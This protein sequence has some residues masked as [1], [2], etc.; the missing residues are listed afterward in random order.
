MRYNVAQ[1]LKEGVGSVRVYAV[2]EIVPL[3]GEEW[4][5]CQVR[6]QVYLLRT[7]RSILVTGNLSSRVAETCGRCLE[8]YDQDLTLHL[9]EEF[10]PTIDVV[11]GLPLEVPEEA[12]PFVIDHNHTLDLLEAVRQAVLLSVPMNPLC[13]PECAGLC[14]TCGQNRNLAPCACAAT[15]PDARWSALGPL[16]QEWSTAENG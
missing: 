8:T 4:E 3:L 2:D 6:G 1:Q 9:E 13:Q 10:F 7:H 12:G 14:P 16:L 5:S 11:T 15:P